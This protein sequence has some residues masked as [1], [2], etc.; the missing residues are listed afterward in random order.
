MGLRP[1][2]E[3]V[4][5]K[6]DWLQKMEGVIRLHLWN[7][8]SG[9][10]TSCLWHVMD[11]ALYE[12]RL[13][14]DPTAHLTA[15]I[16][17]CRAGLKIMDEFIDPS[18]DRDKGSNEVN[19]AI[20]AGMVLYRSVEPTLCQYLCPIPRGRKE[21]K[22]FSYQYMDT[23][24][25]HAAS[26]GQVAPD[27]EESLAAVERER[28]ARLLHQMYALYMGIIHDAQAGRRADALLKA[29]EVA[30]LFPKRT[31]LAGSERRGDCPTNVYA[32][33]IV[34]AALLRFFRLDEE[35]Q[36]ADEML[37]I[38][39]W[40][41]PTPAPLAEAPSV[42]PGSPVPWINTI[43]HYPDGPVLAE[44]ETFGFSAAIEH[45]SRELD[46][47]HIL[48]AAA[49]RRSAAR[50]LY[51]ADRKVRSVRPVTPAQVEAALRELEALALWEIQ[52]FTPKVAVPSPHA[53]FSV[54]AKDQT[55]RRR[56]LRIVVP[57]WHPDTRAVSLCNH[58]QRW[59]S[60]AM[61]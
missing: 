40:R 7:S 20:F 37:R 54:F 9:D 44:P 8:G 24:L 33:D 31:R 30:H 55:G 53:T 1:V 11:L 23:Q 35:A 14:K 13:G 61:P 58:M 42:S 47:T 6:Q 19:D 21:S 25:I 38:H 56:R 46:T 27:W 18:K 29:R 10:F 2:E 52:D 4:T 34:L 12:W 50:R 22:R 15:V 48:S 5:L 16:E 49:N 3:I 28:G 17:T 43:L 26:S 39:L 45:R 60:S 57:E 59:A 51:D 36:D 32:V 41:W